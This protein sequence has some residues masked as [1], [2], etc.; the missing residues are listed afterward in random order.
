VVKIFNFF[1]KHKSIAYKI[2]LIFLSSFIIVYLFPREGKF[3]YEFQKG[4]VWQYATYFA[5]FDFSILKSDK[6]LNDDKQNILESFNPYY[7]IDNTIK[8][9]IFE[10]YNTKINEYF[11]NLKNE[12]LYDSLF[13]YGKSILE[14]IYNYGVI[15]SNELKP[16]IN[17]IFLIDDNIEIPIS[18]EQL[19]DP[20][21]LF[22]YLTKKIELNPYIKYKESYNDLFFDLIV[23]NVFY[24]EKFNLQAQKSLLDQISLSRGVI[25]KGELIIAQG[26]VVDDEQIN[27]LNSLRMEFLQREIDS[28]SSNSIVFGYSILMFLIFFLLIMF[29]NKYRLDIYNDNR[30]LTFIFFNI[31]LMV[32]LSTMI[33]EYN[34]KFIYAAPICITPLVI[35]VFF[36]TRLALFI[37]LI[38][39]LSI[40][41]IVPNSFEFIFLQMIAGIIATQSI[42]QFYRRANIFIAVSQILL[43]Y[44]LA[45]F[46]FSVIQEGNFKGLEL[47][48]VGLFILNGLFI[49]FVL[50]LIYIYEKVFGLVSDVS[51]LELTDT[52]SPLL[53]ELSDK[54]PGTFYHS[55]QVANL[56]EAAANEINANTLLIRVGALYH[57]IG[58]LKHPNYYTE[59]LSGNKSVHEDLSPIN[60]TKLIIDHVEDGVIIA[61]KN[62]LPERVIDFIKT[63]HGTSLVYYFYKK[64]E[65][66]KNDNYLK[67]DF[68]YPGPKPFSKETAI[69][70]MADSVEA[71]SKS[72]KTPSA[73]QLEDFVNKIVSDKMNENQFDSSNITL[74]E[75]EIVK[76]VLFKK[77]VNIYQ[78]R[79]EYPE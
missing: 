47:I 45:Y 8:T 32:V 27:I 69:L 30:K 52:N 6:E 33:L 28:S 71:A 75:I 38:I 78:L 24:D 70:M 79:I 17:Q 21:S 5:P 73:E 14:D 1:I 46:S 58:K 51:L 44:F 29:L 77:L 7:R 12:K 2:F 31:L 76:N 56:A 74:K 62:N 34:P 54:A 63:H 60:S 64:N 49:L 15:S 16:D 72:L 13:L 40:G 48:V 55:L 53:K 10:D 67:E 61:K 19:F 20:S 4:K 25:R 37:H 43:V 41:F 35:K 26:E 39:V 22:D 65:E 68:Q 23:P 36:D 3:K 18:I 9:K 57:D 66:L 50:P 42:T 11:S 59:N